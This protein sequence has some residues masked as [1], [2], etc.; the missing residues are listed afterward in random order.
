[1]SAF[2]ATA[3]TSPPNVSY[4]RS[5]VNDL[6]DQPLVTVTVTGAVGVACFTIEEILPGAALAQ[7]ISGGGVWLPALGAI[8]WGPFFNTVATNVS[9]RLTGPV[10]GT[11]PVNGGSWMDGQW[12]FSNGVTMVTVLPPGTNGGG[13]VPA[14]PPQVALPVFSTALPINNGSF[15]SPALGVGNYVSYSLMSPAQQTQFGWVGGQ[16]GGAV[17][18]A[19]GGAL[20]YASVPDGLQGVSLP[21]TAS[22]S[23]TLNFPTVGGY[24]LSWEA[25]SR[26]GQV[27]PYVVQVDGVTVSAT[28]STSNTAWQP[29]SFTFSITN[30]GN[31]TLSFVALNPLGG[32][33]SVGLDAVSVAPIITTLVTVTISY[34]T[35]GAAIYYTLDGSLPT[36]SSLLYTGP[37][38]LGIPSTVR[39]VGFTNVWTPSA[40]ALAYYGLPA[41]PANA[42]VM[43]SVSTNPPAAPIVTFNVMPGTNAACVALTELLPLGLTASNVT[44]GGNYI[45]SN[46]VVIW[47]P[48]F[49]TNAQALSYQAVGQPGTYPVQASWSVDGIGGGETVGTNIVVASG[50]GSGGG[51]R[52]APPQVAAPTFSPASGSNVPVNVTISCAT[53][54][55]VVYYTLDGSLPTQASTLYTGAVYLAS[56][57]TVRAVAFTNG[58]TSSVASVAY[59]GPP[60]APTAAQVTRSVNTNP[61][62]APVVTFYVL[63]GT[64]AACVTVTES[65]PPGVAATSVAAGG[66]YIASNN[67]VLWGPF[68]GTNTQTLSYQAAGLPGTYPVRASWSVDGVSDGEAAGTNIVVVSA[69]GAGSGFP[70][71]PPQEP[72]PTLTPAVGSNLPVNVSMSSSDPQAQIYFTADG[73]LPTQGSTR[74][75]TPLT[76]SVPTCLRAVGFRAGYLPSVSAVGN[77]VA[78]LPTNTVS[79]VR[80]VSGNGTVLPSVAIS[81]TPLGS[82]N[83][84]AVT[85]TIVPGLTPSGLAANAVWNPADNTICWGPF[86]DSQPRA[87]TYQLS[88]PAGS[89]PLGGQGSFD[90]YP[91]TVTGATTATI[92]LAYVGPSTNYASCVTG[93]ISYGVD[94]EPAPGVIVLDT[95]S[96]TINW[97]DGTQAAITQP[98]MTLQEQYATSGSYTITVAVSWTGHTAT[99]A[100]SGNGIKSDTVQVYSSCNPVITNQPAN[101][102]VL[103]GTTVQFT[104]G[105]SSQFPLSYQWYFNQTAPIIS[106]PTFATLT[107]PDVTVQEAGL[108]SVLIANAYGSVTSSLATLT[109]VAP[110]VSIVAHNSNG[111]M[112]LNFVGLPNTTSRLW[113]ATN[114]TPPIFWE[115]IFTNSSTTTD[116]TWQFTDTNTIHVPGRFYRFSTP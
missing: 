89:F 86:L 18:F 108:Y 70:A 32:D 17:M 40:A 115:P 51:V 39:A 68:F 7:S 82:V 6:P 67:V 20:G 15:E 61:P 26:S 38:T 95:A 112:T 34:A 107:L 97:G 8:R 64:N 91:V 88:G 2:F 5:Y 31:H 99:T 28:N 72:M 60:A 76:I 21:G 4:F 75:T 65:L 24:T 43:R 103:S 50:P 58:W 30:A 90:G 44:A 63:P 94:I 106:P 81:A 59:Y 16:G 49:G 42:Q 19:N 48:F 105:A 56:A 46:N 93:P 92:S 84:Y 80:S 13:G 104:V 71:A 14:P 116:G 27:N 35:P 12:Y 62:A 23:Q 69:S 47:G 41:A 96:G 45:A 54:G 1:M 25:A 53:T 77:Y 85:E 109:V 83:C 52:T 100:V 74:Y 29:T 78:A 110:V 3:Q 22:I 66:N 102:V 37:L 101:Q 98:V 33:H 57:S 10:G 111:S 55:A 87:L 113:A 79:L 9:Y 36:T 11:Y 73:S 114:L